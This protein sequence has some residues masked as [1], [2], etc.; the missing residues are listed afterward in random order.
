MH[1]GWW[2][3]LGGVVALL[4]PWQSNADGW[5]NFVN[6]NQGIREYLFLDSANSGIKVGSPYVAQL[7]L[8]TVTN[9]WVAISQPA[10]IRG[11]IFI[12][13]TV[14]VPGDYGG[15]TVTLQVRVWDKSSFQT[16]EE[17]T[18]AYYGTAQSEPFTE[19]LTTPPGE[20]APTLA[21]FIPFVVGCNQGR[22]AN[23]T[24]EVTTTEGVGVPISIPVTP[25]QDEC[26]RVNTDAIWIRDFTRNWASSIPGNPSGL[27]LGTLRGI[28]T[29][30]FPDTERPP[31]N[32]IPNLNAY[33]RDFIYYTICWVCQDFNTYDAIAVTVLPSPARYGP[34]LVLATPTEP[35]LLGLDA[36]QYRIDRST[37]LKTWEPAGTVTGN[38]STVDLSSFVTA[39][40]NAHFL[41][42]TDIT[43]P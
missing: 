8:Q 43:P 6:V 41:R 13:G 16:Y 30:G 4:F 28:P 26:P 7:Y 9:T 36:H 22:V 12:G 18:H 24:D 32:Y 23:I 10:P 34:T 20:P 15:K 27:Q 35:S 17:A 5:I 42:A 19:T 37:D 14:T 31:F 29:A 39:G 33:G 1:K 2:K 25:R 3:P 38:Y 11:G 40:V 21:H